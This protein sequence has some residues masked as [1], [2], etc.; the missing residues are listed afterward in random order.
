MSTT[1]WTNRAIF[2]FGSFLPPMRYQEIFAMANRSYVVNKTYRRSLYK[3][4]MG[5][6]SCLA[7]IALYR[8]R[9]SLV[10]K[11]VRRPSVDRRKYCQLSSTKDGPVDHTERPCLWSKLVEN[12]CTFNCE[13]RR[14]VAK[15]AHFEAWKSVSE[16]V[17]SF[18]RQR[19]IGN[20]TTDRRPPR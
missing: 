3:R 12:T 17:T 18:W 4:R 13:D 9:W 19:N 15:C 5:A 16:A 14:D 20:C 1:D 8:Q 6:L 11:T 2:G 10:S 7:R